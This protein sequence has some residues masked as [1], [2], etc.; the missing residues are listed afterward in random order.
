MSVI[1]YLALNYCIWFTPPTIIET[2][3]TN[4]VVC[5]KPHFKIHTPTTDYALFL[6][7]GK[8]YPVRIGW[9]SGDGWVYIGRYWRYRDGLYPSYFRSFSR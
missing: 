4:I 6:V 3:G 7:E 9:K 1:I 2:W 8:L 5:L